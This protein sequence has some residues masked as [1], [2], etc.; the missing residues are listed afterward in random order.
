MATEDK[1]FER[2]LA[3]R[4]P[5]TVVSLDATYKSPAFDVEFDTDGK[6]LD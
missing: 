2:I 3:V 5:R 4:A 1:V 6:M